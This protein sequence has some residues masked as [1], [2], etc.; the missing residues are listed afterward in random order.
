MRT[1]RKE[2]FEDT[3]KWIEENQTLNDGVT[4]SKKHTKVYSEHEY[5][6]YEPKSYD[7][8]IEV[9]KHRSFEAV[10]EL[11]KVYPTE[12]LA[13]LNFA[14]AFVPGGGVKSGASAQEECLCR[15]STLY[16]CLDRQYTHKFYYERHQRLQDPKATDACIYTQ[17]I[18]VCKTDT[19]LPERMDESEWVKCDVITCAAP[20][21]RKTANIHVPLN[22]PVTGMNGAILYTFHLK[23]AIHL[24]TVL[25]HFKT[26]V[27]V[28]GA[29]GCGAFHNDPKIVAK[30]YKDALELMK[31]QFKHIEFAVYCSPYETFNYD[32]FKEA[33]E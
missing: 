23:R 17:D 20:D 10:I 6:S 8:T 31:G 27:V 19:D 32:A 26:E 9:T 16:P 11:R 4:L 24:L 2:I 28:L 3:L 33:F 1:K 29:F 13:V 22:N 7:T 30:A 5:P 14:N 18:I 25:A 21:L 12:R 15:T